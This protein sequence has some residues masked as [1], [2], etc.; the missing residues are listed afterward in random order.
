MAPRTRSS[1]KAT[2]LDLLPLEVLTG[3]CLQLNLQDLVRVAET[4]KRFRLGDGGLETVE[5]PTRLPV[6]TALCKLAFPRR[7][8]IPSTRPTGCTESWVAY[9]A[10]CAW[11]RCCFEA[12]LIVAGFAYSLFVD[13]NRHLLACG[14]DLGTGHSDA[15]TIHFDPTPV[16][17]MAGVRVRSAAAGHSHSLAVSWDGQV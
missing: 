9:L 10:R 8:L 12:P 13:A 17:T 4:C 6:V 1:F 2:L 16:A 11:Q 3:V 5:L 14:R 7:E 15:D